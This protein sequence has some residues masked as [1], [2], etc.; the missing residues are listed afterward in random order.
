MGLSKIPAGIRAVIKGDYVT[1]ARFLRHRIEAVE[2]QV[3]TGRY[4]L[5]EPVTHPDWVSP[6]SE[7]ALLGYFGINEQYSLDQYRVRQ[8]E[9]IGT[10][11][12]ISPDVPFDVVEFDL[13]DTNRVA[14]VT[15]EGAFTLQTGETETSTFRYD[16]EEAES[17]RDTIPV[18]LIAT[19]PADSVTFSI[20]VRYD[21]DRTWLE[22]TSAKRAPPDHKTDGVPW[23][24]LPTVR[25]VDPPGPPVFVFIVEALRHDHIDLFAPVLDVLGD[26]ALVPAEPRTQ[27]NWTPSSIASLVSGSYPGDHG[28]VPDIDGQDRHTDR[29]DPDLPTIGSLLSTAH[30]KCSACVS[31]PRLLGEFGFGDNFHRYSFRGVD[32]LTRENDAAATVSRAIRWLDVDTELGWES[33]GYFLHFN[34]PHYP[35]Y[36]PFAYTDTI[37]T[38]ETK[39]L[40]PP[41]EP[42]DYVEWLER[43]LEVDEAVLDTIRS[44]YCASV[45]YT[46]RQIARFLDAVKRAGLL[47][48]ALVVVAGDHGQELLE[49]GVRTPGSLNDAGKRPGMNIKPPG[50]SDWDVPDAVD[51][52]DLLPT[53]ARML[54]R[55]VSDVV[56]GVPLQAKSGQRVRLTERI[57]PDWYNLAVEDGD[58]KAIF[59]YDTGTRP[60]EAAIAEGPDRVEY[61]SLEE[62]RDGSFQDIGSRLSAATK[63]DLQETAE[64]FLGG[65]PPEKLTRPERDR[66]A[67]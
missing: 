21:R 47:D 41:D 6:D 1:P 27:G 35:Y 64:A 49:R 62:V 65:M 25:P 14:S 55:D 24:G 18:H 50:G 46:G 57:S 7:A 26:D 40:R 67:L 44:N 9:D 43:G 15:V 59:T 22:R 8:G 3:E 5:I 54:G 12:T 34:D 31:T 66:Q 48:R 16:A 60:S 42:E 23:L 13:I 29:I 53:V 30:Y 33:V 39:T 17:R 37:D 61:Y 52:V 56:H 36:P 58:V 10:A 2:R 11:V 63:R 38:I 28:Y 4:R 51:Y 19:E 45:S 32:H 20:D